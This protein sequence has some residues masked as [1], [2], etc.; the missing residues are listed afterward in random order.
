M[1]LE[2]VSKRY[3]TDEEIRNIQE[4]QKLENLIDEICHEEVYK[5][6]N[7]SSFSPSQLTRRKLLAIAAGATGII[8][9][10]GIGLP[11]HS[12]ARGADIGSIASLLGKWRSKEPQ[13]VSTRVSRSGS[14]EANAAVFSTVNYAQKDRTIA[15]EL[16][17]VRGAVENTSFERFSLD[18]YEE[19]MF[20]YLFKIGESLPPGRKRL[21]FFTRLAHIFADLHVDEA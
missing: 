9:V 4:A 12:L 3:L 1:P 6:R 17:D 16:Q 5:Q 11:G 10:G 20:R 2:L 18:E 19:K 13:L 7:N 8:I 21:L 15:T 14:I